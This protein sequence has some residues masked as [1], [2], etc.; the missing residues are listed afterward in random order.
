MMINKVKKWILITL[1]ITALIFVY[2]VWHGIKTVNKLWSDVSY[3]T[4]Y[5]ETDP[6]QLF[7]DLDHALQIKMPKNIWDV[8]T[9]RNYGQW[10][11]SS[12]CFIVKFSAEPNTI[13]DFLSS[14]PEKEDFIP[15]IKKEDTRYVQT[16]NWL[17]PSWFTEPINIGKI[18]K[19]AN[20]Y[21][22]Y[23]D[24]SNKQ[25]YIVYLC[26]YGELPIPDTNFHDRNGVSSQFNKKRGNI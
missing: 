23:I 7:F 4:R 20:N 22:I 26:G 19:T 3:N 18:S 12:S 10:D 14:L 17:A 6:N 24:T 5:I 2:I 16:R 15:Y 25:Q 11:S 1:F 21:Q 9:A 13:D 8:N